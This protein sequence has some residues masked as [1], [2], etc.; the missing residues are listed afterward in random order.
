MDPCPSD[1]DL[2]AFLSGDAAGAVGVHLRECRRCQRAAGRLILIRDDRIDSR[3]LDARGWDW[4]LDPGMTSVIES[5]RDASP[6]DR[7]TDASDVAGL[8]PVPDGRM[9]GRLG[10]YPVEPEV[11]RGGMGVVYRA[12]D[13]TT[14]R[15]VALKV[16]RRGGDD[17]RARRRFVQEV[18]AASV[19]HDNIVRLYAT[20]DPESPVP[21]FA[22]E[23]IPGPSLAGMNQEAG[24]IEPRR[25]AEILA[26]VADGLHAAHLAGVVHGDLK[27]ANLLVDQAQG[28]AKIGDFGLARVD[29]DDP[30]R[31]REGILAGTPAYLSPEQAGGDGQPDALTDL[32][33]LGVTLYECLAGEV[34]FRGQPHRVLHQIL[35]DDPRP[36]RVFRDAIP[37]DLETICLKAMSRDRSRR[38]PAALALGDD[39]RR[40][41]R[42]D[43]VLARPAGPPERAWRWCRKNARVALLL[44][45]VGSRRS[46]RS[47]RS[48]PS[49]S[50]ASGRRRSSR[51]GS[52]RSAGARPSTPTMP[53]SRRSRTSSPAGPGTSR[54]ARRC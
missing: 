33:S 52:P 11:G 30:S 32:Y 35:H 29:L 24:R 48:R 53:S 16:L 12:R 22:M 37:R 21:Y 3:W 20:S 14:G 54:F 28:R 45:L 23:Y 47:R 10:P 36:P 6:F 15:T 31:S 44:A 13:E 39:L 9:P 18:R 41:L 38:Y 19:E 27:P 5:L 2:D 46:R 42:G 50:A 34:P 40:F 8:G 25:V 26:Q 49:G 43:S 1:E 51:P 4:R 17:S 7:A